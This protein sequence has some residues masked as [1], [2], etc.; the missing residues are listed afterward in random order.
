[1]KRIANLA[2]ICF[3]SVCSTVYGITTVTDKGTWPES[4]PR[5]LEPL[6]EQSRTVKGGLVKLTHYEIPFTKREQFESVWPFILKVKSKDGP[7]MLM[8]GPSEHKDTGRTISAGVRIWCALEGVAGIPPTGANT[9]AKHLRQRWMWT[10]Y[11][12][13]VVDGTVVDLNRIPL[14]ADTQIIDMRFKDSNS[15]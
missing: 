7:L 11:I 1:M 10:T 15:E 8:S 13:L 5:E 14:P 6:R 12:E 3:C 9:D 2:V 4:W